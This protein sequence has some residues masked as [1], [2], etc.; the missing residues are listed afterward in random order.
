[1][2]GG[3][4]AEDLLASPLIPHKVAHR[5]QLKLAWALLGYVADLDGIRSLV[6][7]RSNG[8]DYVGGVR[9]GRG[10]QAFETAAAVAAR[11]GG[12]RP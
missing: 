3:N 1:M 5:Y 9:A 4:A 11:G 6:Q 12:G 7:W 10:H 8:N 2:R